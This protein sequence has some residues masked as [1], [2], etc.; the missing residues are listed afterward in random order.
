MAASVTA[1]VS[2]GWLLKARSSA[3]QVCLRQ[4]ALL[5]KYSGLALTFH[6]LTQHVFAYMIILVSQAEFV[7]SICSRLITVTAG[8]F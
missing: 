3:A 2:S 6:L 7:M 5:E 8:C 1:L 4:T